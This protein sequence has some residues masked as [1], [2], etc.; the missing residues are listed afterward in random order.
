MAEVSWDKAQLVELWRECL[1]EKLGGLER[2]RDS[3]R[4]GTRVDGDHRPENRGERASVTSQGYLAHGLA[5]R[6]AELQQSLAQL[7]D[8]GFAR[9]ERV[10]VGAIVQ[11]EGDDGHRSWWAV[12]PG[13]DATVLRQGEQSLRVLS[14]TSPL[15]RALSGLAAGD[16]AEIDQG[17]ED[18]DVEVITVL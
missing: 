17:G 6:I 10:S 4:A 7:D 13:G 16:S 11:V 12:F 3:A 5:Q 14:A 15:A 8:M 18:T 1:Q 2:G 9:R